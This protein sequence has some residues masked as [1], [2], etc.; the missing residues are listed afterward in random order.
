[1]NSD[2]DMKLEKPTQK[3]IEEEKERDLK[4]KDI[5]IEIKDNISKTI[6]MPK[7]IELKKC[8]AN[9]NL[10]EVYNKSP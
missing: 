8:R 4:T 1:M 3:S 6:M 10:V 5:K 9:T 7:K 2:S